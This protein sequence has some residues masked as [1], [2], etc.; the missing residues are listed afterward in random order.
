MSIDWDATGSW[1]Q[2]WAGF[3]QAGVL[4]FA[5][6]KAADTFKS[7][8]RQKIEERRIDA[9]ERLLTLAYKLKRAFSIIRSPITD[10]RAKEDATIA[11]MGA[12]IDL[13]S[14]ESEKRTRVIESQV[15]LDRINSF[16]EEWNDVAILSPTATAFFG[17]DMDALLKEF[18]RQKTAV[19]VAAENYPD[20]P[21]DD[22]QFSRDISTTIWEDRQ[23]IAHDGDKVGMKLANTIAKMEKMLLPIIRADIS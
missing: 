20:D 14:L 18:W 12:G 19:Q 3:A 8:R 17:D 13:E 21:G 10:Q 22:P 1:M 9:A 15:V 6:W 5:A 7:W 23:R 16:A 4:A 11:L 2:A